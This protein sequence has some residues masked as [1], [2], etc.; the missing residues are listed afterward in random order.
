MELFYI[1]DPKQMGGLTFL[2]SVGSANKLPRHQPCCAALNSFPHKR[3][4][5]GGTYT[6]TPFISTYN[7]LT[8]RCSSTLRNLHLTFKLPGKEARPV[9]GERRVN[10]L[11]ITQMLSSG[12]AVIT[13]QSL[14]V[15]KHWHKETNKDGTAGMRRQSKGNTTSRLHR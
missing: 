10:E 2:L 15:F 7:T 12:A 14:L 3:L 5:G 13:A 11:Y 1:P 8:Q 9:S 6:H 4:G